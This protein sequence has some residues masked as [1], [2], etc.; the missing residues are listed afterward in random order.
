MDQTSS[1][2]VGYLNAL[3]YDA[4][5]LLFGVNG[6]CPSNGTICTTQYDQATTNYPVGDPPKG[7]H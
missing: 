2:V 5:A 4:Y 6:M 1:Q 3:G 7:D